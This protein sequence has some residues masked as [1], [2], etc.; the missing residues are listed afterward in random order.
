VFTKVLRKYWPLAPALAV[1][2]FLADRFD[3]LQ[4]DAYISY[5]F[6]ANF[7][8]GHGLVYNIGERVEGFTNF[9][10]VIYLALWGNLGDLYMTASRVT[11]LLFGAGI[12][13][14]TYLIARLLIGERSHW[15]AFLPLA[16][17]ASNQSLAC[18]SPAGLETAAFGFMTIWSL[19]LY[20]KRSPLLIWSVLL[21]VGRRVLWWPVC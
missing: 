7:L 1:Y 2:G 3:Y 20:L 9:G 14:V 4:D 6:V 17:I 16:L 8:N 18:W 5:R 12:I 19:Y 10:W 13:V 15:F 11:G 21:A